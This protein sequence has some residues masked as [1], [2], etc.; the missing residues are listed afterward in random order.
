V[1]GII[2]KDRDVQDQGDPTCYF[3]EEKGHIHILQNCEKYK[4]AKSSIRND[5]ES[6]VRNESRHAVM[7]LSVAV[8][9]TYSMTL[10]SLP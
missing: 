4:S 5:P 9:E 3:C 10:K 8:I 1:A 7:A 2:D 6:N